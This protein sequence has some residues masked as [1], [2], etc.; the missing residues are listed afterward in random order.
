[1]VQLHQFEIAIILIKFFLTMPKYN[2]EEN[3]FREHQFNVDDNGVLP[4]YIAELV[5]FFSDKAFKVFTKRVGLHCEYDPA[6]KKYELASSSFVIEITRGFTKKIFANIKSKDIELHIAEGYIERRWDVTEGKLEDVLAFFSKIGRS[7]ED[8]TR[9]RNADQYLEFIQTQ[10]NTIGSSKENVEF[11]YDSQNVDNILFENILGDVPCY[12]AA[13]F[14]ETSMSLEEAQSKKILQII[15]NL[16]LSE[17][18]SVLDIGSGWGVLGQTLVKQGVDFDGIT[19]S[20]EQYKYCSNLKDPG[21]YHL[22]DYRDFF[23]E[24]TKRFDAITC[25]EVLDHIGIEQYDNFFQLAKNA[26]KEKGIFYLQLITRP[27][28]GSTSSWINNHKYPGG[29]ITSLEEAEAA[30]LE[31]WICG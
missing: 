2:F 7:D 1:M 24:N 13:Y 15:S 20:S 3:N 29:Y 21:N 14:E 31:G 12:S 19:I 28:K 30:Y 8:N 16:D 6:K 23:S 11:H 9:Q 25:I 27:C 10:S 22:R 26:L 4:N 5:N 18:A 17:N